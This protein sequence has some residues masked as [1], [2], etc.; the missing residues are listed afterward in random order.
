MIKLAGCILITAACTKMGFMAASVKTDQMKYL[1]LLRRLICEIKAMTEGG[2][3]FGEILSRLIDKK[4]YADFEFLSVDA[5]SPDVRRELLDKLSRS[6]LFDSESKQTA[7]GFFEHLG[8]TDLN[9]QL[10]YISM[11][12]SVLDEQIDSLSENFSAQVRLCR[13]LGI[14]SGAF[15]S[16]MLI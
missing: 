8:A 3:T 12:L 11:A 1:K 16:V 5:A 4:E 10:A 9:G 13:V 2:L 14:L 7:Y 15:I 6:V